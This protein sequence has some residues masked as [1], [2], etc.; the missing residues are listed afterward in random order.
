MTPAIAFQWTGREMIPLHSASARRS[1][2]VGRIYWLQEAPLVE[3]TDRSR[4]HQFA[5]LR[6]AWQSLPEDLKDVYPDTEALRKRA[7]IQAGFYDETAIEGVTAEQAGAL[8]A[9][10]RRK[11]IFS[12][13]RIQDGVVFQRTAKSQKTMERDEFERSKQAIIAIA[14]DLIGVDVE[15]L[16]EQGE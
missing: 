8:V 11:D 5:I 10:L 3:A 2:T 15:T 12:H 14:A 6:K 16:L 7:L 9:S 13:V 4:R 1:Y